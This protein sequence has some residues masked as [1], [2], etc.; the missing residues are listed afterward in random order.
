MSTEDMERHYVVRFINTRLAGCEYVIRE[1]RASFVV[2]DRSALASAQLQSHDPATIYVLD[3]N[4]TTCFDIVYNA[5]MPL[6]LL[7]INHDGQTDSRTINFHQ[8]VEADGVSFVLRPEGSEWQEASAETPAAPGEEAIP[9]PA[10]ARAEPRSRGWTVKM[11]SLL[12]LLA[13]GVTGYYLLGQQDQRQLNQLALTLGGKPQAFQT[14]VGRDASVYVLAREPISNAWAWQSLIKNNIANQYTVLS[15]RSAEENIAREIT[16]RWPQVK[17]HG[18][19]FDVPGRP[20]II[21]SLERAKMINQQQLDQV[22][23]KLLSLFSWASGFSFSYLSDGS[24]ADNAEQGL[25]S[26][27]PHFDRRNNNDSVTFSVNSTLNDSELN[28][29]KAFVTDFRSKWKGNYI[30]FDIRLEDN[31]LKGKSWRYGTDSYIK[32]TADQWHFPATG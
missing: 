14:F 19:R 26:I 31:R 9:M 4:I 30:Q 7:V 16:A 2:A 24:I 10:A 25:V 23:A 12:L 11:L 27:V 13:A 3:D 22:S 1:E 5:A 8:T 6:P 32:I 20:E 28:A 17:F 15:A 18:V 29:L 21:L